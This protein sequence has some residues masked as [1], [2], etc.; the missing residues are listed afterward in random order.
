MEFFWWG[1][2]YNTKFI[3]IIFDLLGEVI[4][5]RSCHQPR[6]NLSASDEGQSV[7][8]VNKMASRI[9]RNT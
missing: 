1:W 2:R 6:Y 5:L 8:M 3:S 7:G 9:C 4:G